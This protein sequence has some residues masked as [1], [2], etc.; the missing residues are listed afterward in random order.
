VLEIFYTIASVKDQDEPN[1]EIF[2]I[3]WSHFIPTLKFNLSKNTDFG[4]KFYIFYGFASVP[5]AKT[6]RP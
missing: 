3:I 6:I 5:F 1:Q 4:V 2:N